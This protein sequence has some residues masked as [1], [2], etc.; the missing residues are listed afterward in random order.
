MGFCLAKMVGLTLAHICTYKVM[1][2]SFQ[3]AAY[4]PCLVDAYV[5][6]SHK[7]QDQKLYISAKNTSYAAG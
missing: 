4:C 2:L 6:T 5:A 1:Y 3:N 7:E